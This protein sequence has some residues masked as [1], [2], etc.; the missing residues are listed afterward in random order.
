[1]IH[2]TKY[3]KIIPAF[4]KELSEH[5]IAKIYAK[6]NIVTKRL[7]NSIKREIVIHNKLKKSK[8]V[9]GLESVYESKNHIYLVFEYA[10]NFEAYVNILNLDMDNHKL[11]LMLL[12]VLTAINEINSFQCSICHLDRKMIL[13]D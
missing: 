4:N 9:L 10:E 5:R 8:C 2:E 3:Y 6:K 1:M 13:Y 11:K 7:E 12:D